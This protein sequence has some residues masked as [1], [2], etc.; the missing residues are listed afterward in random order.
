MKG[1]RERLRQLRK[2]K[3]WT[4]DKMARRLSIHRT[5]YTKYERE[6]VN[7]P[8]EILC[9]LADILECTTDT[10]LGRE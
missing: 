3:G 10:L 4:Q 5:T 2:K 8:L 1:L 7:P 6:D 9:D